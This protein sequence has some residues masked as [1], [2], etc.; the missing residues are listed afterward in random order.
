MYLTKKIYY[1]SWT[2]GTFWKSQ[3]LIPSKK[4]QSVLIAKISSRR[5]PKNCQSTK[6]NSRK[7]FVPHD[8]SWLKLVDWVTDYLTSWMNKLLTCLL[9]YLLA[10]NGWIFDWRL[11]YLL[12]TWLI[13]WLSNNCLANRLTYYKTDKLTDWLTH[14]LT[15]LLMDWLI[16]WLRLMCWWTDFLPK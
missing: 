10:I 5:T 1:Q 13:D 16:G 3:K 2:L 12:T 11:I 14:G 8:I 9:T 15:G 7:N 4:N 6:I